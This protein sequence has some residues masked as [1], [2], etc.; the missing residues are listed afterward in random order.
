MIQPLFIANWKMNKTVA[1][2]ETFCRAFVQQPL[3][4]DRTVVVCSPF[5]ALAS[6]RQIL[7]N[8]IG[9]GAQTMHQADSGAFTGEI[10]APMLVELS[11]QYVIIGHSE[12]RQYFAETDATVHEK[13]L[14]A[15][16]YNL[17]PIVC[18]G[19]LLVQ[20]QNNETETV[21]RTQIQAAMRELSTDQ[22]ANLVIAYEPVWAI[23]TGLAATPEQA[24][25][26]HALIRS[27]TSAQ[28]RILYGGSVTPEN[29]TSLMAQPDINGG[30]VGGASLDVQK[31]LQIINY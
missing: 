30:L 29:I 9:V 26:V 25:A 5:T 31:F 6:I 22:I 21:V 1:E 23:G 14:T 8:T 19:E 13:I 16:R 20:R 17:K 3:P 24:Q 10:S 18:V 11:C 15:L 27:L 2:A 7:P 4:I 28:T 12:R